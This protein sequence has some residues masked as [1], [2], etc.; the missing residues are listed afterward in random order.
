MTGRNSISIWFFIG[1][2]LFIYGIVIFL[3]NIYDYFWPSMQH[4]IVLW[5]LHF[6]VWWGF[7]LIV[8][9]AVYVVSFRPW[10]KK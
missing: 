9:G 7:L 2:L 4:Q 10:K 6:G 1:C 3:A 5:Q 8:I